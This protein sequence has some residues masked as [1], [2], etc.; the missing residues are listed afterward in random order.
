MNQLITIIREVLFKKRNVGIRVPKYI[1]ISLGR[2]FDIFAALIK[3]KSPYKS[4]KS[5]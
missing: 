1:G 5:D 4:Y 3:K 2:I